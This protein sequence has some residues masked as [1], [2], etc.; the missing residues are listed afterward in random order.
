MDRVLN[1]PIKIFSTNLSYTSHIYFCT[2]HT[3]VDVL[4]S[5]LNTKYIKFFLSS[6]T[7]ITLIVVEYI[8]SY[9]HE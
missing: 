4:L 8:N 7:L 5:L 9:F 3:Q 1:V 2:V 6:C